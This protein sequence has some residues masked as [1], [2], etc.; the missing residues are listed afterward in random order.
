LS[1]D[2]LYKRTPKEQ[3]LDA[4]FADQVQEL[5]RKMNDPELEDRQAHL[6]YIL[7]LLMSIADEYQ[8]VMLD[9][10]D[11][12]WRSSESWNEESQQRTALDWVNKRIGGTAMEADD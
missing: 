1:Q 5:V 2:S 12:Y 8:A 6:E 11:G 7:D 4:Y 9:N 3:F 10:E